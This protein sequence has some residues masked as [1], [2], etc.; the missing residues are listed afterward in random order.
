MKYLTKYIVF[1]GDLDRPVLTLHTTGDGLVVNQD[2]Q[3]YSN[4]AQ[5]AGDG[6]ML[7]EGYVSRAG[8]CT[9]TP[10]ETIAAFE[11]VIH[12]V[13][14]GMWGDSTAADASRGHRDGAGTDLQHRAARLHRLQA[15]SLPPSV[16]PRS[17]L[18]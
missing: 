8:H 11:T 5:D 16:R 15:N 10:A 3:A 14:T 7:R 1:N 12:R 2:E 9:F 6:Q 13:N 4:V 17:G 18:T